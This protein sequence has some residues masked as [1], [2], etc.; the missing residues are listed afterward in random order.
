MPKLQNV[1]FKVIN[2]LSEDRQVLVLNGNVRKKYWE[3]DQVVD[4]NTV[5]SALEE[6]DLPLTIKLNSPGG[7]VFEGIEIYNLLKDSKREITIEVTA[8]AASAASIIAMGSDKLIMC[9]GSSL[10]L[11]EASSF[12]WGNKTELKKVLNAL[13]TIDESL[14]DIYTDKTGKE[15]TQVNEWLLNETWFTAQQAVDNGLADGV[16]NIINDDE[17]DIGS[18]ISNSVNIKVDI[19]KEFMDVIK[20]TKDELETVKNMLEKNAQNEGSIFD[21]KNK[22]LKLFGGNK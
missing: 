4:A 5:R 15:R 20:E 3:D 12:A 8:L 19:P 13:D 9:K 14:I 6:S 7:D 11:H 17:I 16:K 21:A 2:E 18:K 1:P 10:M 22:K